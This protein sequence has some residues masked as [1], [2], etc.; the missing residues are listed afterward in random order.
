MKTRKKL[1][2]KFIG[3][4]VARIKKRL[5][6]YSSK[7][8]VLSEQERQ[9]YERRIQK[10]V[11]KYERDLKCGGIDDNGNFTRLHDRNEIYY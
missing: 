6:I 10:Q 2:K 5:H 4:G 3:I 11:E 1:N 8:V 9:D 7:K